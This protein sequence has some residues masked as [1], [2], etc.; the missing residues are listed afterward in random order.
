M[1][2]KGTHLYE[3]DLRDFVGGE[4][5]STITEFKVDGNVDAEDN[6]SEKLFELNQ[7]YFLFFPFK[8]D[9]TGW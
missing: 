3:K 4:R 1:V 7:N 8:V 6:L 5:A 2:N 9:K